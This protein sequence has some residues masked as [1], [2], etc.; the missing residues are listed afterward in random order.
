M[1]HPWDTGDIERN[2]QG[3]FLPD[4]SILRN[5]VGASTADELQDAENDLVETRLIELRENPS[6]LG[7]RSYDLAYLQRI[8]QHLFQDVY[9]WA[10]DL[11]TVGIEKGGESFCPPGNINQAMNH[12]V[13][14]IHSHNKLKEVPNSDLARTIAYLYDYVN[15]AHPFRE[16][17]GRSTREFFDLLLSER[18]A[19]FDW[20][21]TDLAELHA[22]CHAARAQSDLS[23]LIAMFAKILDDEPAYD[24]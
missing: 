17:N 7:N 15:F 23:G 4:T 18:H 13:D 2:W 19:G 24:F 9:V 12:V 5:R 20:T 22:A 6:L 16:G 10:G 1:P 8:H 14:E 11:R 21:K 3:Y